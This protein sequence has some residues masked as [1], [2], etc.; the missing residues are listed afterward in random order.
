M[1]VSD[2]LFFLIC[3]VETWLVSALKWAAYCHECWWKRAVTCLYLL[4]HLRKRIL[5]MSHR[6]CVCACARTRVCVWMRVTFTYVCCF[7]F[8]PSTF[9]S[10]PSAFSSGDPYRSGSPKTKDSGTLSFI[11]GHQL[12]TER[13]CLPRHW[14]LSTCD[15][16]SL[17][18]I[19]TTH[20]D[21]L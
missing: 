3:S 2:L 20:V 16:L 15:S 10:Q 7:L 4:K 17:F 18:K 13:L 14:I 11:A 5:M 12:T 19:G 1:P 6:V 21:T 9:S 8:L